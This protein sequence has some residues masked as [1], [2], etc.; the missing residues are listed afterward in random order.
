MNRQR[1]KFKGLATRWCCTR[2]GVPES[3]Y[4]RTYVSRGRRFW[5]GF[6]MSCMEIG[7]VAR[8]RH[9]GIACSQTYFALRS[10]EKGL[11]ACTLRYYM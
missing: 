8:I 1:Y 7:V 6:F 11:T 10:S 4:K 3:I 9:G 2:C 5:E